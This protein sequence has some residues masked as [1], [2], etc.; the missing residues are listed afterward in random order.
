MKLVIFVLFLMTSGELL[1]GQSATSTEYSGIKWLTEK[2]EVIKL[3][4]AAYE[5]KGFVYECK[6]E[7]SDEPIV[8]KN[9]LE[10]GTFS[11]EPETI[12]FYFE[13]SK[14]ISVSNELAKIV[15]MGAHTAMYTNRNH[16]Q[17]EF[18]ASA[19]KSYGITSFTYVQ[20]DSRPNNKTV[21]RLFTQEA[22]LEQKG[23]LITITDYNAYG[24]SIMM[25]SWTIKYEPIAYNKSKVDDLKLRIEKKNDLENK[26][27]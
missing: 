3:V 5:S 19:M 1:F 21:T 13:G 8:L 17:E 16:Q 11:C 18:T 2:S 27:F 22:L 9:Q 12:T 25:A 14:L 4:K 7:S 10:T 23:L 24:S 20:D 15:L 6:D 26:K